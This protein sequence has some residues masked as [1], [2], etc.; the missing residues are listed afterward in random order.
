M[1]Q[2]A[3]L[4]VA[5]PV[6]GMMLAEDVH[7]GI[8]SLQ[9]RLW[10]RSMRNP[11]PDFN[12][13]IELGQLTKC[14]ESWRHLLL[15]IPV[16]EPDT[17]NFNSP[18]RW[19][20]RYYY[21]AEDHTKPGWQDVVYYRQK[22]LVY[23]GIVLYHLSCLQ[24]YSNV[25]VL[26]HLVADMMP[27]NPIEVS[28]VYQEARQRRGNLV[29]EWAKTSNARRALCHAAAI[30]GFYND[31]PDRL[32]NAMDPIIYMALSVAAL[33][34]WAYSS[35]ANHNCEAF[36]MGIQ[37]VAAP[38]DRRQ[39]ELTRWR[40]LDLEPAREKEKEDW[41]EAGDGIATLSGTAVC[42]CSLYSLISLY[43]SCIPK[44]WDAANS[45]APGLFK[46]RDSAMEV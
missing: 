27:T 14:L 40:D 41:I 3:A 44:D 26:S 38:S 9:S 24:L 18:Q 46:S 37:N 28:D 11:S 1:I 33:V 30:L 4:Y 19:A 35:F 32:R 6:D 31:I 2:D 5:A 36:T 20:T 22:T 8:C 34:V 23:D 17:S 15:R 43:D 45:I 7:L 12:T 25:R 21:G 39:V 16:S 10:H 42:P 29:R 13:L